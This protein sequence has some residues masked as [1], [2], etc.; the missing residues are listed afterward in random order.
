MKYRTMIP[1]AA[2]LTVPAPASAV[3]MEVH[4]A[5]AMECQPP[6]GN[7]FF[8]AVSNSKRLLTIGSKSG[9]LR[10]NTIVRLGHA[11]LGFKVTA[12]GLDHDGNSRMIEAF[13]SAS[14]GY[15]NIIDRN[16]PPIPCYA[17]VALSND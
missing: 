14:G 10:N 4:D 6:D 12:M 2:M 11:G 8:V 15:L 3:T 7:S 1:L 13:F 16:D 5:W 9:K 17:D